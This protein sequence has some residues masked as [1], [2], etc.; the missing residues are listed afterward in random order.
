M[1]KCLVEDEVEICDYVDDGKLP[2]HVLRAGNGQQTDTFVVVENGGGL[3]A[4]AELFYEQQHGMRE[5]EISDPALA[6]TTVG[7]A[8]VLRIDFHATSDTQEAGTGGESYLDGTET[9]VCIL[10][11]KPGCPVET[12]TVCDATNTDSSGNET[13]GT[14]TATV[15][16]GADGTVTVTSGTDTGDDKSCEIATGTTRLVP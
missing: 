16:I 7:D 13:K 14:A 12:Y 1:C 6:L 11:G 15:A 4:V 3:R 9:A 10:D 2:A 8:R 5:S